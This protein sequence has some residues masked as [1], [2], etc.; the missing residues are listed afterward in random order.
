M[1]NEAD[2]YA[3]RPRTES[4]VSPHP[5]MDRSSVKVLFEVVRSLDLSA[6]T[7]KVKKLKWNEQKVHEYNVTFTILVYGARKHPAFAIH[8]VVYVV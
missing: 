4:Q 6:L 2:A 3:K 7:N 5:T 1:L 8:S